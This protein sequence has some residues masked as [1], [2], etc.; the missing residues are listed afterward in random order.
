MKVETARGKYEKEVQFEHKT[1]FVL[2][3]SKKAEVYSKVTVKADEFVGNLGGVFF[4]GLYFVSIIGG[5][6]N[7]IKMECNL[8]N[9]FEKERLEFR[10]KYVFLAMFPKWIK[11]ML[12]KCFKMPP[13]G[14]YKQK[15]EE[16][17]QL[18]EL[19]KRIDKL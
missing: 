11:R 7:R 4:F 17:L 1:S 10:W 15:G 3:K 12:A 18:D 9:I 8:G 14:R 13:I 5:F 19:C 6:F 16:V 2:T